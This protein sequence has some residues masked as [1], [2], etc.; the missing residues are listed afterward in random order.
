MNKLSKY[1]TLILLLLVPIT[2]LG[3][4]I[5]L[6]EVS[7]KIFYHPYPSNTWIYLTELDSCIEQLDLLVGAHDIHGVRHLI[8]E[9]P[10][11]NSISVNLDSADLALVSMT[12]KVPEAEM[13]PIRANQYLRDTAHCY[14]VS[15]YVRSGGFAGTY[16][17]YWTDT[18]FVVTDD[19]LF[20]SDSLETFWLEYEYELENDR[21]VARGLRRVLKL[22]DG[23]YRRENFKHS[24]SIE[25]CR[26]YGDCQMNR[27][28][29]APHTN[30]MIRIMSLLLERM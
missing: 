11:Y 2:G 15:P 19:R 13:S 10:D 30:T 1:C 3:Q 6:V 24:R 8:L 14:A 4:E 29:G 25:L 26:F 21:M 20:V 7:E 22:P 23:S 5:S 27:L 28:G 12:L 16:R 9:H 17:T 18:V